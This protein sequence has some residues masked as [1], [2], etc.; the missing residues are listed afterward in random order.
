MFGLTRIPRW[1]CDI[2]NVPDASAKHMTVLINDH[3]YSVDVLDDQGQALPPNEIE[4]KLWQVVDDV[5][6]AGP[7]LRVGALSADERDSWT[8]VCDCD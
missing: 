7:A 5:S 1:D 3:V 6:R 4:N 8:K 2:F